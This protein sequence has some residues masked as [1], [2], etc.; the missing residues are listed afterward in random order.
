[1]RQ[2]ATNRADMRTRFAAVLS[3]L[4][5]SGCGRAGTP[6]DEVARV[7]SPTGRVDAVLLEHNGGAGT[8]FSYTV[9]VVRSGG[10]AAGAAEVAWLGVPVRNHRAYGAN[11]RWDRPA[12]L[13]IE[14]WDAHHAKP[15]RTQA[16][17]GQDTVT[18]VLAA[19]VF[20][21][22]APAGGMRYN[23]GRARR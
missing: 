3:W 23:L 13:H 5:L 18:I 7:R 22:L 6:G 8:D 21:S 11:L 12:S 2:A 10:R 15:R 19:G 14:Y 4:I 20:D 1:M 16:V 17:I 9:Y